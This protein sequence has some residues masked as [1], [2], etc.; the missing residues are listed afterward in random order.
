MTFDTSSRPPERWR[1]LLSSLPVITLGLLL[2]TMAMLKAPWPSDPESLTGKTVS[3]SERLQ[4]EQPGSGPG[5]RK[6]S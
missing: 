2:V 3:Y 1:S 5:N 4:G 6:R